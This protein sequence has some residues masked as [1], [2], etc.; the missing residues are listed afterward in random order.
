[1]IRFLWTRYL[2]LCIVDTV[3]PVQNLVNVCAVIACMKHNYVPTYL[4]WH[5]TSQILIKFSVGD[6][7]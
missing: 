6:L 5:I 4:N 1:V 7:E 2:K 3:K